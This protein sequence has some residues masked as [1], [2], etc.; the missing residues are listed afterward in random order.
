M[1]D[2]ERHLVSAGE[3]LPQQAE[4]LRAGRRAEGPVALA[5]AAAQVPG[6]G[7]Q[8]ARLVVDGEDR[9]TSFGSSVQVRE[10]GAHGG[11][12]ALLRRGYVTG[13]TAAIASRMTAA[14]AAGCDRNTACEAPSTSVTVISARW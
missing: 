7:R 9:G 3:D 4:R 1:S 6:D 5:E 14:T 8:N 10:Q 12:C 11:A 2:E 13:T